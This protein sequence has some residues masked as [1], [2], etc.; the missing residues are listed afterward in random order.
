V[1]WKKYQPVPAPRIH[2]VTIEKVGIYGE[3]IA[4]TLTGETVFV[5]F[6]HV[7]E[8]CEVQET[9]RR[10][11]FIETR[12][13][14]TLVEGRD[15]VEPVCPLFTRC[16]GCQLQHMDYGAQVEQKR[17][18]L[19]V[20][21][22]KKLGLEMT[23]QADPCPRPYGYRR[24]VR[25]RQFGGK[26][27]YFRS[28]T[29][30]FLDVRSC[31]IAVSEIN[32]WLQDSRNFPRPREDVDL[33]IDVQADGQIKT[34]EGSDQRQMGF[35]QANAWGEARLRELICEDLH[36]A[37]KGILEL[38]AGS[39]ALVLPWFKP[40]EQGFRYL[41]VDGDEVNVRRGRELYGSESVSF[42]RGMLPGWLTLK[43]AEQPQALDAYDV[44][45]LDPPR[46]GTNLRPKTVKALATLQRIIYISCD[47]LS[48]TRDAKLLLE[49]THLRLRRLHMIDM[50]PQTRHFE[51]YSLFR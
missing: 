9:R 5:P 48:W 40:E 29:H 35:Q 13:L 49:H 8:V 4:R 22:R 16:G 38:Y 21:V 46:G 18:V 45:V 11:H 17:Q 14:R 20:F 51:I 7:G 47:P 1:N 27:G 23:V 30:E 31:P 39:G 36:G 6:A 43:L 41:G 44:L 34:Y 50:F 24:R 33:S 32:A 42:E 3:G 15:R 28:R 12:K 26:V 2:T 10:R 19:Q 25:L 37:H